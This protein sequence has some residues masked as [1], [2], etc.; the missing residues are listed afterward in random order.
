MGR[1]SRRDES[2]T[3]HAHFRQTEFRMQL[4]QHGA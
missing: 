1:S 4:G 2:V 3:V